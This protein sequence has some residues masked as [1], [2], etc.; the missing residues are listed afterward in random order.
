M[1]GD[2]DV[3][4][5]DVSVDALRRENRENINNWGKKNIFQREKQSEADISRRT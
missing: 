2:E 1:F 5:L 3:L 4:G